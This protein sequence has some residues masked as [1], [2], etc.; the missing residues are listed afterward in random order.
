MI[1][2]TKARIKG[3]GSNCDILKSFLGADG[4][5]AQAELLGRGWKIAVLVEAWLTPTEGFDQ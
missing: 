4:G 2:I 1:Y 5:G 3:L